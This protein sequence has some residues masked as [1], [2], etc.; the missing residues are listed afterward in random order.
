MAV[1]QNNPWVDLL[2]DRQQLA[3]TRLLPLS[4]H[5]AMTAA[6][7]AH[8]A[9]GPLALD[10][11]HLEGT[12]IRDATGIAYRSEY[13]TARASGFIPSGRRGF[14]VDVELAPWSDTATEIAVR[15]AARAPHHWSDRRRRR[16]YDGAHAAADALRNHLLYVARD[17]LPPRFEA[18]P[19]RRDRLAG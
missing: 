12:W 3:V 19:V 18:V 14:A 5:A 13:T 1:M 11:V 2:S 16:W 8:T 6:S 9:A 15:P 10:E 7:R 4:R 17:T